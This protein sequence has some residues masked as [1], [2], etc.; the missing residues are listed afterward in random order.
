MVVQYTKSEHDQKLHY[1][2]GRPTADLILH[3]GQNNRQ[4]VI[5]M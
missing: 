4:N 3:L 2:K 5:I 1:N